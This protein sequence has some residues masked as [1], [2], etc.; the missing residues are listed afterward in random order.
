MAYN[1]NNETRE[2][3]VQIRKNSR[4]DFITASRIKNNNTG[5]ENIDIR[6][7]YT[8]DNDELK[9][10]SKGVR[11]NAESLLDVMEGLAKGLEVDEVED[12]I[13]TLK[14]M[15]DASELTGEDDDTSDTEE[16]PAE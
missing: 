10:T 15:L 7:Y 13:D 1:A 2:E 8:D 16:T 6:Q 4:G 12:L 5:N 3:L 9:P 11:F 14:K